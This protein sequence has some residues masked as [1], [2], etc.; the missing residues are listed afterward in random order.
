MEN[1]SYICID[2]KSFYATAE[3]AERGLD[4]FCTNLVVADPERSKSTICLAITPAMK[5]AGVKNRCRIH[6]IPPDIPYIVAKPRM[7]Y[8]WNT[9]Q[10]SMGS[11]LDISHRKIFTYIQWMNVFWMLRII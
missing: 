2:L 8:I 9:P 6:E 5:Q 1:K 10:R 4:P 3:C 7:L 11:I